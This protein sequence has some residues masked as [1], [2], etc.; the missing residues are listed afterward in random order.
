M[1]LVMTKSEIADLI[2]SFLDGSCEE[3]DWDDFMN[4][5]LSDP[6]LVRIQRR[7]ASVPQEYPPTDRGSYC[8][9]E[10]VEVLKQMADGLR[11]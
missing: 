1:A 11:Q 3:W 6:D 2:E 9:P 10:G 4:E 7:C 8:G 5:R